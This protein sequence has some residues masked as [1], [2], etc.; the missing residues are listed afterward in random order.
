MWQEK[1]RPNLYEF[2][3]APPSRAICRRA[4]NRP[5][6]SRA[7]QALSGL[8]RRFWGNAVLPGEC[9]DGAV[10]SEKEVDIPDQ[11]IPLREPG[12]G[13]L[14]ARQDALAIQ[15]FGLQPVKPVEPRLHSLQVQRICVSLQ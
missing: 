5:A 4:T 8:H 1:F 14:D 15:F 13:L 9:K 12:G 10:V 3:S 7:R 2:I 6:G 11:E